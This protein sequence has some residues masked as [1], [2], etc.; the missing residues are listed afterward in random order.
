MN[1]L[2]FFSDIPATEYH[3]AA[4][5]GK[6]LSSHLLGDFRKSP[7]L[8]HKKMN[9]EIEP[10][11]SAA[12]AIG[13]AVHVLVLEGR[14]K[15]NEEFLV[16]DGPVNPKTGEPFGKLTKA[17]R[18]WAAAQTKDV[19]SGPDFA[20]MSKLRESVWAHPVAREL[21]DDGIAEQ[22]VRTQ[23]CGE[24][25]QIRADWF[26]G[27]YNGRPAIVDLKTAADLT[28]FEGDARRFGYPQQM[29]FY[30][31][32]LRVA[33]GGEIEADCYLIGIE[34]NEP[35][36]CGVWKLTDGI[37]QACAAENERAI[38]ELRECRRCNN[39]PTR[40]EDLRILDI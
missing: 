4:R 34:K 31:E 13:R 24:P 9:G 16:T 25:C 21:L 26:R 27:D 35:M 15:F 28:Y 8:Y 11:E 2:P 33:S 12:L 30:R 3:E 5:D 19:V 17:Y 18:E 6:F 1:K 22:T 32:V 39:W 38:A 7:K 14:G 29:A 37:L 36:R 10:T 23:Y 40:T 20:F